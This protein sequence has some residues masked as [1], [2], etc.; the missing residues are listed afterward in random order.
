MQYFHR[1]ILIYKTSPYDT[2]CWLITSLAWHDDACFLKSSVFKRLGE[3]TVKRPATST[4]LS[5]DDS[6]DSQDEKE[7]LEYVGI[8]KNTSP[9]KKKKVT[10]TLNTHPNKLKITPKSTGKATLLKFGPLT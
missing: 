10:V 1:Y 8:F 4:V 7:A 6:D 9:A 5:D 2:P 3:K